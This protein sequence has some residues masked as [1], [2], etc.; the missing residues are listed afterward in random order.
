LLAVADTLI[1]KPAAPSAVEVPEKAMGGRRQNVESSEEG[2]R[3]GEIAR[4]S[5]GAVQH[6]RDAS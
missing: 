5:M 2:M 3:Q 1:Q 6:G 4:G